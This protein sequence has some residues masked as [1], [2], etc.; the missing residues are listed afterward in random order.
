VELEVENGIGLDGVN[1]NKME[2]DHGV[3]CSF[4]DLFSAPHNTRHATHIAKAFFLLK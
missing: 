3:L 4:N 1:A 2:S